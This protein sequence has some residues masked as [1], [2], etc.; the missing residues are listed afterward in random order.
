MRIRQSTECKSKESFHQIRFNEEIDS[1]RFC[2]TINCISQEDILVIRDIKG[3][4]PKVPNF[5][6]LNRDRADI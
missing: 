3:V 5:S 1:L 6:N 4:L 2:D